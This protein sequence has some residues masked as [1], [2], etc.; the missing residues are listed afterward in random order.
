[1][2]HIVDTRADAFCDRDEVGQCF[3][4]LQLGGATHCHA[5]ELVGEHVT[6]LEDAEA[7]RG[8]SAVD[9]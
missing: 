1:M 6:H 5:D 4:R 3:W 2:D 9:E 8:E 7:V